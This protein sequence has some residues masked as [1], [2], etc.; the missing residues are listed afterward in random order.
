MCAYDEEDLARRRRHIGFVEGRRWRLGFRVWKVDQR[1]V[2]D[3]VD[4][5]MTRNRPELV[6]DLVMEETEMRRESRD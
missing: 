3:G 6:C 4:G 1:M 5:G 2:G